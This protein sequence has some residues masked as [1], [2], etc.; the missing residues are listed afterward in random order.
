MKRTITR[1][2]A[3]FTLLEVMIAI[4]FIGIAM[5]ALLSLHHTDLQS[6]IRGQ[7]LTRASM[8]A[9]ALMTEAEIER[10]PDLGRST[11][12]FSHMYPG[13]YPGYRWVREVE[14]VPPFPNMCRVDVRVLYGPRF[15]RSF[16]LTEY[17]HNPAPPPMP[18]QPPMNGANPAQAPPA[19][20]LP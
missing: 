6:V 5:I 18:N 1:A 14:P 17:M 19:G 12:D 10:V 9:Q 2:A 20:T 11:G 3:A 13:E 15:S 4:A 8:L 16:S 7:E